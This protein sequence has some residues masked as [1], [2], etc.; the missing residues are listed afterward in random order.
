MP[1]LA[2]QIDTARLVLRPFD[3]ADLDAIV[4]Y[5][6]NP[7]LWRYLRA[8]PPAP[9]GPE[10][11]RMFLEIVR[12]KAWSDQPWYAVILDGRAVGDVDLTVD[13][14]NRRGEIG[15]TLSPRLWGRGL[16]TEAA[17]A[18]VSEAF[19]TLDLT[20]VW[21]ETDV[22]NTASWRVMEKLGMTR[23]GVHRRRYLKHG[24]PTDWVVY[25]VLAEEWNER[26]EEP[27]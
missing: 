12:G 24:V 6:S 13:A 19:A 11:A 27:R 21:A 3:D 15:Y 16:A 5:R 14:A 22:H 20:V 9:Y 8:E 1:E 2:R 17:T 26:N 18:I 23:E 4:E 10:H 25:S 7:R